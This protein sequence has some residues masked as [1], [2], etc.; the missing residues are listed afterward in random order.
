M[1]ITVFIRTPS[2]VHPVEISG[3][4]TLRSLYDKAAEAAG[5]IRV[6][7][8]TLHQEDE[9]L[10]RSEQLVKDTDLV[11]GCEVTLAAKE[12]HVTLE[13]LEES[14]PEL[15]KCLQ[16]DP[17]FLLVINISNTDGK[18][19]LCLQANNLPKNLH[20]V[21]INDPEGTITAIG[22]YFLSYGEEGGDTLQTVDVSGL[23]NVETIGE[24]FLRTVFTLES[25]DISGFSKVT[26]IARMFLCDCHNLKNVD[27]SALHG[28][29]EVNEGFLLG[30]ESLTK[31]DLSALVDVTTIG[32]NFL[33]S[34]SGLS[35]V[36]FPPFTSLVEVE[37]TFLHCC[38]GLTTVDLKHFHRLTKIPMYFI[39]SCDALAHID[40]SPLSNVTH[41]R[42]GFLRGCHSLAAVDLSPLQAVRVVETN[43]LEGTGVPSE[44]RKIPGNTS[45]KYRNY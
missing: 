45:V 41:I 5:G 20:N 30:C 31:V 40:L 1:S 29:R 12:K 37:A 6:N 28:L 10:K 32:S 39:A 36:E 33:S 22:D 11:E 13:N 8:M 2:G 43:F 15:E 16:D 44:E 26:T 24:S 42:R 38:S 19:T 23:K 35:F 34:C 4:E 21:K 9:V 7:W 25:V 18:N 27:I 3:N 14:R 17:D